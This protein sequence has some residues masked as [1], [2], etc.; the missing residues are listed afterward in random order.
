MMNSKI[1]QYGDLMTLDPASI[2]GDCK[3]VS[4]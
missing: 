4:I 2:S 1:K 3:E